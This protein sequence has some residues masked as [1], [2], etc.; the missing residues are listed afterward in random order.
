MFLWTSISAGLCAGDILAKSYII[1]NKE[2]NEKQKILNDKVTITKY[3]NEGAMLGFLKDRKPLL[4]GITV[5]GI[6][7]IW[8]YL[9]A[10]SK[11]RHAKLSKVGLSLLLGGALSNGIERLAKGKVTDYFSINVGPKRLQKIVYNLG[12]IF[13]F[14]GVLMATVGEL[15]RKK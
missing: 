14:A 12:D 8:G 7:A 3:Y 15:F 5:A 13:I 4:N 2:E 1:S 9:A 6:G 11:V 10:I